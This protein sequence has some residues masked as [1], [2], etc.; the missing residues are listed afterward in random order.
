M[1]GY[2]KLTEL[3][4]SAYSILLAQLIATLIH[5]PCTVALTGLTDWSA[6]LKT[7]LLTIW[8]HIWDNGAHQGHHMGGMGLIFTPVL[9]TRLLGHPGLS[10]LMTSTSWNMEPPN[11]P[12]GSFNPPSAFHPPQ[13]LT[14]PLLPVHS[15]I[16][17]IRDVTVV[18]K[19][20]A[21]N[22]AVLASYYRHLWNTIAKRLL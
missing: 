11:S 5:Y 6:F 1:T 21:Q 13:P 12:V 14:P 8:S 22:P 19:K 18:V 7:V 15:L 20:V 10:G 4:H 17:A 9:V 16:C 3:S 2:W